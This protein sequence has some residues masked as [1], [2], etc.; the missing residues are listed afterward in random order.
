MMFGPG[1]IAIGE[2]DL[3]IFEPAVP[4]FAAFVALVVTYGIGVAILAD[5][6]HP[7]PMVMPGLRMEA[8]ARWAVRLLAV[9]VFAM[10]VLVTYNVYDNEGSCLS[11][12]QNGGCAARTSD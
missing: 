4:I 6:L 9:G 2:V 10:A 8:A 7:P 11:S 3:Q 12:D 1:I 5:R